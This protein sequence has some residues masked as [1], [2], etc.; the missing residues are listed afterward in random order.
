MAASKFVEH[1]LPLSF[2]TAYILD[3][4]AAGQV[5][6]VWQCSEKGVV[7]NSCC[8]KLAGVPHNINIPLNFAGASQTSPHDSSAGSHAYNLA[9]QLGVGGAHMA[10]TNLFIENAELTHR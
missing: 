4:W 10:G 3:L 5:S 1:L 2:R 6:G 8:N 7:R 9:E